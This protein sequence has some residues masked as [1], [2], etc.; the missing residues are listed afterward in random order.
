MTKQEFI[1]TFIEEFNKGESERE[2]R[3]EMKT[4]I[5]NPQIQYSN[6]QL[7]V[8]NNLIKNSKNDDVVE[9]QWSE[10]I[11][12]RDCQFFAI[13]G[14]A[15][16][17]LL[18]GNDQNF[19]HITLKDQQLEGVAEYIPIIIDGKCFKMNP[20]EGSSG[21]AYLMRVLKRRGKILENPEWITTFIPTVFLW[22]EELEMTNE[23]ILENIAQEIDHG[24]TPLTGNR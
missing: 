20:D 10:K 7:S 6:E 8:I 15:A 14:T 5:I 2:K 12:Q 11:V 3:M 1:E 21:I 17:E 16:N 19:D 18:R 13:F 4:K 22:T 9:Y 23:E 24:L